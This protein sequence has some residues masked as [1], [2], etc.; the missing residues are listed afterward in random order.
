MN[1]RVVLVDSDMGDCDIERRVCERAGLEFYDARGQASD[2]VGLLFDN[3]DVS[4]VL[5]KEILRADREESVEEFQFQP[6]VE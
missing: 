3:P 4:E 1:E 2:D 5:A 6:I